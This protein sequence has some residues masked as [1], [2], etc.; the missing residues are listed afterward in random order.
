M[1]A[2]TAILLA[3][4]VLFHLVT[5]MV[6]YGLPLLLVLHVLVL[7]L[8]EMVFYTFPMAMLLATLMAFGRLSNDQE[9][10]AFKA[11]GAS[12]YR[13]MV[14]VLGLAAVVAIATVV[15]EE[16]LVPAAAWQAKSLLYEAIHRTQ[17]PLAREHVKNA[18]DRLQM[19]ESASSMAADTLRWT[20][21]R[22]RQGYSLQVD[23]IDARRSLLTALDQRIGALCDYQIA[24]AELATALGRVP[25]KGKMGKP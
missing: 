1:A 8:P 20:E 13:M 18:F 5:E 14:P 24:R 23:V 2:F 3:A 16:T 4:T 25:E 11:A 6:H 7:R 22:Y 10:T 9:L 12:L 21:T 17:L 19:A 15:L